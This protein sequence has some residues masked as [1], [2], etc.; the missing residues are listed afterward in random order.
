MLADNPKKWS[1]LSG[2]FLVYMA[3]NG[4]TLH[5]LPILYP[6]LMEEFGWRES[7]VTLPATIFFI[8]GA[9]TSPPAGW[10]LD[11]YSSRTIITLGSL[12]LSL[13]LLGYSTTHTL[14]E[15]VAIYAVLGIALSLCGLVSNMVM[16]T[17][18]FAES[19]GRATGILLMASSLG[20][21]MFP[22][23]VGIGLEHLGWRHT[24][25]LSG[26]GVGVTMLLSALLLLR[27]GRHFKEGNLQSAADAYQNRPNSEAGLL[28]IVRERRFLAVV[29]ATGS[30]WF[31]IIALTQ[32]QSI[33]LARDVGLEKGLLPTVFSLFF[34]CSVLG[35]LGFGLLAD[36]FDLHK[37]MAAATFTLALSLLLLSEVTLTKQQL[38]YPY[39]VLAGLGFSGAFTCIQ[40]LIA[41]HYAGPFYGRILALIVLID[42]LCGALGTRA[43]AFA[44]EWQGDYLTAL[45]GMSA[46]ACL[47]ALVIIK[48]REPS[49]PALTRVES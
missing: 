43:V 15:L 26:V 2:L 25:L 49:E 32:H 9:I 48:L 39:A 11:R 10:L 3:S 38:I 40:V 46:L 13:A 45:M 42:T 34:A 30:L 21:A 1:V 16:L 28:S 44:R 24:V 29:F 14:W 20:G 18:W 33:F 12:L 41:A 37:V 36:R 27:D 22:L 47:S 35:K 31:I 23:A 4:I 7:E 19:R 6:E 5:T 8:V 17:S